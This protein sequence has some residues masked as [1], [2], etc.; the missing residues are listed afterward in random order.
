[1]S[2]VFD[3]IVEAAR[4]LTAHQQRYAVAIDGRGGAGKSTL[5]RMLCEALPELIHIEYDW[6][7]L[8][9]GEVCAERRYDRQR[10]QAELL[11]P[12]LSRSPRLEYRRYN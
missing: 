8:P 3:Q 12:F 2:T 1:M 7:H 11:E 4:G 5:A 10:F 9:A 6:F